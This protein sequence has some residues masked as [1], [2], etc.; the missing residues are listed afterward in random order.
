MQ[1]DVVDIQGNKVGQIEVADEVFAHEVKEHLLYEVV[2]V[3]RAAARA[4]TH[5]TKTRARVRGGGKKPYKQK[6]TGNA[7]QG[8]TRAPHFVGGGTV[9]G[10]HPRSHAIGMPKKMRKAALASALSLR[11]AE[12]KLI[13][14]DAL[15]FDAPKTKQMATVLAA[16]GM[17]A[18]L[19]IDSK[20]NGNASKSVKNLAKAKFLPPEG[21]NVYDILKHPGLVISKDA[22]KAIEK[23]VGS[24]QDDAQDGAQDGDQGRLTNDE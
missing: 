7:R 5:E 3:N 13:V 1:L 20:E 12:K 8:S 14:V 2:K 18:A 10:P 24:A 21:L 15:G 4:G 22:V 6:G 19:V 11:V 23:R 17:P 16:L 9:F